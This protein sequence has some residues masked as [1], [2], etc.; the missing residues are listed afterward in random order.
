MF[1]SEGKNMSHAIH[2]KTIMI[3]DDDENILKSLSRVLRQEGYQTHTFTRP[4]DALEMIQVEE[5]GVIISDQCMPQLEGAEFL[6]L[7]A[8]YQP[9]AVKIILSGYFHDHAV[10]PLLD[11]SRAWRYI[12]KPWSDEDLRSTVAEAVLLYNALPE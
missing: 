12:A 9:D 1:Y 2:N 11:R 10:A 8:S 5:I 7:I 6:R 4:Y 3:V